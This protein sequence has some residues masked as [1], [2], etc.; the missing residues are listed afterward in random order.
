MK[1]AAWPPPPGLHP[2]YHP[3]R[4]ASA[5]G[6][7]LSNEARASCRY[8]ASSAGS[9]QQRAHLGCRQALQLAE[10]SMIG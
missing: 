10:E 2:G 1:S 5:F 8:E 7:A 4:A 9:G 3:A 6:V